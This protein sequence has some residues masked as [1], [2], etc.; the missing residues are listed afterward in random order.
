LVARTVACHTPQYAWNAGGS[1]FEG[2]A[3]R[4]YA[5]GIIRAHVYIDPPRLVTGVVGDRTAEN[6]PVGDD[7]LAVVAGSKLACE[8]VDMLTNTTTTT[9]LD[10]VTDFEWAERQQHD[11]RR[12]VPQ[13][14]LKGQTH[15]EAGGRQDCGETGRLDAKHPEAA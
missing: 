6:L 2:G 12:E 1:F 10:E 9:H 5:C 8:Q 14:P 15:G 3:G 13:R 4:V 11:S 7:Q